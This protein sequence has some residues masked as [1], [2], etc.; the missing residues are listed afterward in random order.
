MVEARKDISAK[1]AAE[2]I[3]DSCEIEYYDIEEA[4][5]IQE[6][7]NDSLGLRVKISVKKT[8]PISHK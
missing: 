5:F 6:S 4:N 8:P 1:I 7:K 2:E 3:L